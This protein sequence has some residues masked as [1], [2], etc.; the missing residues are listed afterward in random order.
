MRSKRRKW[1]QQWL[2]RGTWWLSEAVEVVEVSEGKV[3]QI[4]DPAEFFEG[5]MEEVVEVMETRGKWR[6]W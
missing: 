3:E 1:R 5:K 6:R 2:S 4:L